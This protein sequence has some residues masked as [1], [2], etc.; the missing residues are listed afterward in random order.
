MAQRSSRFD[1]GTR[2]LSWWYNQKNKIIKNIRV[3]DF[4]ARFPVTSRIAR[5]E[6]E[7][8]F[9]LMTGF[10]DTQ[11]LFTFVKSGALRHLES[12]SLSIEE[13]SHKIGIDVKK[14]EILCRA[15]YALGLVRLKSK[16]IFL[17]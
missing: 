13:L 1:L 8:I 12:G 7:A 2:L 4:L 5:K 14:T 11:I 15:G 6:G 9:Q 17:M 10:V 3:Q 16:R